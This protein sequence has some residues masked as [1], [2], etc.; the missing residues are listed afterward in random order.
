MGG[1][2]TTINSDRGQP[3]RLAVFD[4][5]R[6][7]LLQLQKAIKVESSWL[8]SKEQ[9]LPLYWLRRLETPKQGTS[10]ET[11]RYPMRLLL[12]LQKR[13]LLKAVD[14]IHVTQ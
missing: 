6:F 3:I 2:S 9:F 5:S 10:I 7:G 12:L 1:E 14:G 11:K 4:D 13:M 8:V